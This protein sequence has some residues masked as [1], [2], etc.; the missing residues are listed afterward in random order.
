MIRT[1][2]I[3][4]V[5]IP[6]YAAQLGYRYND[7]P[8]IWPCGDVEPDWHPQRYTPTSWPGGRP[9]SVVMDDGRSLFSRFGNWF[10]LVDF[11]GD[12][13]AAE[14]LAAATDRGVPM[15][16]VMVQ[17]DSVRELWERDLVL[18][19]PDQHVGW[20][21]NRPSRDAGAVVSHLIGKCEGAT[22]ELADPG[23]SR[24]SRA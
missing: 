7:S 16:Y 12:G 20:R 18:L 3:R 13:R 24:P 22:E 21:G 4:S 15:R 6:F 14:L 9:P 23:A 1:G 11:V 2:M 10:T 19:R 8:I 5:T 17:S